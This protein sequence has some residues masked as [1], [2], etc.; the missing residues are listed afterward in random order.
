[1]GTEIPFASLVRLPKRVPWPP[2][3][4]IAQVVA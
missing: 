1:L 2:A 4:T 3:R